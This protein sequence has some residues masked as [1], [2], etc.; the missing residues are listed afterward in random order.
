MAGI[1]DYEP[2]K[3]FTL[4]SGNSP[5]F[6]AMGASPVKFVGGPEKID[7]PE[8]RNRITGKPKRR[9]KEGDL[10]CQTADTWKSGILGV[11]AIGALQGL[12]NRARIGS[13][14]WS[15]SSSGSGSI[16]PA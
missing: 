2:N 1:G 7:D 3:K 16:V 4:R 8:R 14:R 11:T 10:A 6:I 9:C 13:T 15:K 5:E 12:E